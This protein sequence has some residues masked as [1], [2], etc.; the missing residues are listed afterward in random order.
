MIIDKKVTVAWNPS[1]KERYE[2]IGYKFT[3]YGD[4]FSIKVSDLS[5]GSHEEVNRKC[6]FCGEISLVRY[7]NIFESKTIASRCSSCSNKIHNLSR[8]IENALIGNDDG[9][10]YNSIRNLHPSIYLDEAI[11]ILIK[12]EKIT[13]HQK[14]NHYFE[15]VVEAKEENTISSFKGRISSGTKPITLSEATDALKPKF[16]DQ[17]LKIFGL[18]RVEK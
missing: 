7:S 3:K 11:R 12:K 10:S 16:M 14:Y 13:K 8:S 4:K 15:N 9:L 2:N 1:N 6:D 18:K 17:F 5:H